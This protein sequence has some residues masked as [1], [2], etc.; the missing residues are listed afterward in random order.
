MPYQILKKGNEYI[1]KSPTKQYKHKSLAKAKSQKRLLE[2]KEAKV[3]QTQKVSQKVTVIVNQPRRRRTGQAKKQTVPQQQTVIQMRPVVPTNPMEAYYAQARPQP[4]ASLTADESRIKMIEEDIKKLREPFM[5]QMKQNHLER[6][7]AIS[8]RDSDL[9][10]RELFQ[11]QMAVERQQEQLMKIKEEPPLVE[12]DLTKPIF[13]DNPVAREIEVARS[14]SEP[15]IGGSAISDITQPMSP[16]PEASVASV[17]R[18]RAE[19]QRMT[20]LQLREILR[21]RGQTIGKKNKA[22][23]IDAILG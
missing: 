2:E 7:S 20:V 5:E 21:G 4:R 14:L 9:L 8:K 3:V 16:F 19:L 18:D 6:M 11:R 23:L 22:E 1:L 10:S 12:Y 15:V 17:G 13:Q